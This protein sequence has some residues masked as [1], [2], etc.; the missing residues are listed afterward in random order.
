MD[1]RLFDAIWEAY[2]SA[3]A[4][5]RIQIYSAYRSP[6]TNAMLRPP[7]EGGGRAFAAHAGQGDGHDH[8]GLPDVAHPRGGDEARARRRRLVSQRELRP[9]R[10][11]R[12]ALVAAHVLRAALGAV[13]G[14]QDGAHRLERA[15]AARLRAGAPRARPA[16]PDRSAAGPGIGWLPRLAVRRRR[17]RR[18]R[19]PRGRGGSPRRRRQRGTA[20]GSGP[21]RPASAN[22]AGRRGAGAAAR[23]PLS[24]HRR[25]RRRCQR[26]RSSTPRNH[27]RSRSTAA[28]RSIPAPPSPAK[29]V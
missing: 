3:G 27:S 4:T 28:P 19:R 7:F 12:R 11:R 2:R 5:D 23:R 1:P 17:H 16:R 8:A 21:G 14:R 6:E 18:R 15:D 29:M 13:P 22:R 26:P 9:H 10:R 20:A 24:R 25:S